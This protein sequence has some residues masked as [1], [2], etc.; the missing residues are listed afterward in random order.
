MQISLLTEISYLIITPLL[1]F[2]Y[3]FMNLDKDV[4]YIIFIGLQ[5][6]ICYP[7]KCKMLKRGVKIKLLDLAC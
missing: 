4:C 6:V 5:I 7:A 2:I 3:F 1:E